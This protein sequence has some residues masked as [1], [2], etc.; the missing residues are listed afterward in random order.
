[1]EY[2]RRSP[3]D[4]LYTIV[5]LVMFAAFG[6]SSWLTGYGLMSKSVESGV[7]NT[8]G[9][10]TALISAI[11]AASLIGVATMSLFSLALRAHKKQCWHI[12]FLA[13]ALMPFVLSIST[14]YAV[15]GNAGSASIVYDLRDKAQDWSEYYDQAIA[16][17]SAAQSAHA[18]LLPLKS[19]I[20]GLAES[21][22]S[23]GILTGSKGRGAVSAA[24]TSGC[25]SVST[26]LDTL[27]ETITRTQTRRSDAVKIITALQ[28]IPKDSSKT[29]FERQD[30]FREQITVL[31][32]I[33]SK[34]GAEKVSDRL[35]A[36]LDILKASIATLGTEDSAF[37]QK[38]AQAVHNLKASLELVSDAVSKLLNDGDTQVI[39]PPDELL[40]SGAAVFVYWKRN[41]PN[42]LLAIMIDLSSLYFLGLLMVSRAAESQSRNVSF[43][44]N[45][46]HEGA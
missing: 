36:Q 8:T 34:S 44:Q 33:L 20:C 7:A 13:M 37:G 6:L 14:Y 38:Q 25:D 10:I 32:D 3:T 5:A 4:R 45:P 27:D 22:R 17:A 1:M 11:T 2:Q 43:S 41:I 18:A 29:A 23:G 19:S 46:N 26:I 15:I 21:E 30:E 28:N 16:D 12:V 40:D 31:L 24:Y 42:I 35:S 9:M 39:T